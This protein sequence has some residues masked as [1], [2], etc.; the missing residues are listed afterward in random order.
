MNTRDKCWAYQGLLEQTLLSDLS[1]LLLELL[2]QSLIMFI[3][4]TYFKFI[5]RVP[6]MAPS[7]INNLAI[8]SENAC[9][10]K[11]RLSNLMAYLSDM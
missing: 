1:H 3:F 5:V 11:K 4:P 10:M 8:C 7:Y 2:V 6:Y 9:K